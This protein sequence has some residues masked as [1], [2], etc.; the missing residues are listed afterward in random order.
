MH[1]QLFAILKRSRKKQKL[2]HRE[3]Y[4]IYSILSQQNVKWLS[5][6]K[7]TNN[8]TIHIQ[9]T[10]EFGVCIRAFDIV[11]LYR[12]P[13]VFFCGAAPPSEDT[14]VILQKR[15]RVPRLTIFSQEYSA[16]NLI[17]FW[18]KIFGNKNY[19][20]MGDLKK[21]LTKM[22]KKILPNKKWD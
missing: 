13:S 19:R 11:V 7:K 16:Q 15:G 20:N 1:I 5:Y 22:K 9:G 3:N 12:E 14:E 21:R 6:P 18:I 8:I 10:F 4:W 17:F 2:N